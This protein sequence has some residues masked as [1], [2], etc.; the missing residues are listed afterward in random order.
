MASSTPKADYFDRTS[1]VSGLWLQTVLYYNMLLSL[2]IYPF[3][4][5]ITYYKVCTRPSPAHSP[6]AR[7]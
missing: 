6:A 7:R 5:A 3:L 1:L 2:M 4:I